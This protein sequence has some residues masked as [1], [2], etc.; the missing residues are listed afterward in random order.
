MLELPYHFVS[1]CCR[2][3]KTELTFQKDSFYP[4]M[5][6]LIPHLEKEREAYGIKEVIS[7]T[8][9]HRYKLVG[10]IYMWQYRCAT[11]RIVQA[12]SDWPNS[13]I[14]TAPLS[15]GEYLRIV[16]ILEMVE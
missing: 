15:R 8:V 11:E 14:M 6:L 4:A 10:N 1:S 5:R 2:L 13:I 9:Y 12:T 7:K 3:N 16:G